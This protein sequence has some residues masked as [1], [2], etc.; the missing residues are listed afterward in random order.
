M[1]ILDKIMEVNPFNNH[2]YQENPEKER[3]VEFEKDK[4]VEKTLEQYKTVE[5]NEHSTMGDVRKQMSQFELQ[6]LKPAQI[7]HALQR[8]IKENQEY[9]K[10]S[11][12][13]INRLE[14]AYT[15][16]FLSDLVQKS[17][18]NG[19]NNFILNTQD[20]AIS[21]LGHQLKGTPEEPI[22]ITIQGNTG[23]NCGY[24]S[25]RCEFYITGNTGNSCGVESKD[26]RY[27]IQGD[28]GDWFSVTTKRCTFISSNKK[29][30]E[31]MKRA[32]TKYDREGKPAENEVKY[33]GK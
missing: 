4:L 9:K 15:G 17:F 19:N 20:A 5:L 18:E 27:D 23:H 21:T 13:S 7:D 31:K 8:I 2:N 14:S 12:S 10:A 22:Q 24:E 25:E 1:T 3:K 6:T 26:C 33:T 11:K 29:T 32:L 16:E 28:I 30:Y